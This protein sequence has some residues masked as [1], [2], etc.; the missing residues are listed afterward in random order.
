MKRDPLK[1]RIT[2]VMVACM[3]VA[4][5]IGA[6]AVYVQLIGDKRLED[7]AKKQ[8]KS[9][10]FVRP[11]RGVIFDR[12][13]E[14]IAVNLETKSVA[15][16]P[17]K[18]RSRKTIA[19]LL[20]KATGVSYTKIIE[21][22]REKRE[23]SWIKRHITESEYEHMRKWQLV[24]SGIETG[25]WIVK[26]S[27]RVYPHGTLASHVLGDVNLDSEGLEGMELWENDRL[28]GKVVQVKTEKDAL[29][30]P[31][32]MDAVAAQHVKDGDNLTLT[33]D[34]SLQFAVEQEL[35][36]LVVKHSARGGSV[37]V[38]NAVTGEILAMANEPTFDPNVR[39]TSPSRR[40]NRAVTDGYEPGSTF[41]PILLSIALLNGWHLTDRVWGE[42]GSFVVQG[43]RIS[44]AESHEKF[45]W[46]NLKRLIQVSSN[47]GAAKLALRL[48]ADRFAAGLKYFGFGSK[49]NIGFP[50]EI[51]GVVPPR[52]AWQPLTLANI[53]FGQGVL[54]TPVQMI[55]AYAAFANGG[56]LVQPRLAMSQSG[57]PP[58]RV[59]SQRVTDEVVEALKT[60]TEKGGTGTKAAIEGYRVAGK[61]GTAQTVDPAT[62][63]YSNAVYNASFIGFPVGVEPRIVIYT[64]LEGPRGVYYAS[65]TAA[66]LFRSV[67]V[68]AINRF[69]LPGA[70]PLASAGLPEINDKLKT[71]LAKVIPH[72][73]PGSATGKPSELAWVSTSDNGTVVW[74]MPKLRGLDF[75]EAVRKLS[76]HDFRIETHGFGVVKAQS[77]DEGSVISDG[78]LVRLTMGEP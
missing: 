17:L 4:G 20:S 36:A 70:V 64:N 41:K 1:G 47:I 60:T 23:F 68:A 50:G 2:A 29:G 30:R 67:L 33:I 75:R 66:P 69:G 51:S 25:V 6:R 71:S 63:R 58:R 57:G 52:R 12:S 61:T 13:G 22:L 45:E 9:R 18:I 39:G 73:E 76:G 42:R 8:F 56:W 65:E 28:R 32:F 14:P 49:I 7:L 24:D 55:R 54:V 72:P 3:M 78:G 74:K 77:P 37:I 11:R 38:M 21:K 48:G 40:R 19:R 10:V 59:L 44:E 5:A 62:G 15:V 43:K 31:I 27:K 53:G 26:E 34:A 35:K 46:L 16:N